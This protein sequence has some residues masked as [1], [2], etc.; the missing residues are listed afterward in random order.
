MWPNPQET[1]DLVTFTETFLNEKLLFLYSAIY[2]ELLDTTEKPKCH[3]LG[4][5]VKVGN[6][7]KK[8]EARNLK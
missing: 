8:N 5:H 1:T 3:H 6:F 2:P 7:G 4:C